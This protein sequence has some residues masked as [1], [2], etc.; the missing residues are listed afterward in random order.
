VRNIE[1]RGRQSWY[2]VLW[3]NEEVRDMSLANK[4]KNTQKVLKS[5]DFY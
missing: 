4:Y 2:H 1:I 3:S 5:Q